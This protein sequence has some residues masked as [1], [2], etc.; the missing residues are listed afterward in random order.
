MYYYSQQS[1]FHFFSKEGK[2][3]CERKRLFVA[4]LTLL[5]MNVLRLSPAVSNRSHL[6][7]FESLTVDTD[8]RSALSLSLPL[9]EGNSGRVVV[10]GV[11]GSGG[12]ALAFCQEEGGFGMR[13]ECM[14]AENLCTTYYLVLLFLCV[15]TCFKMWCISL[16]LP[17]LNTLCSSS[18]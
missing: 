6:V 1:L 5:S 9:L 4:A 16:Y 11:A 14:N 3:R 2:K 17:V 15:D 12:G 7:R 18:S 13:R 10:G 8:A